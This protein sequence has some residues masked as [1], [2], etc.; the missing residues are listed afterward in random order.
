[1]DPL[2]YKALWVGPAF[3]SSP[4]LCCCKGPAWSWL[5]PLSQIILNG[6]GLNSIFNIVSMGKSILMPALAF[7]KTGLCLPS[8]VATERLAH[9]FTQK[10]TFFL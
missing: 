8:C 10:A 4:E 1:M 6:V 2:P 9:R 5:E 7:Q 3:L